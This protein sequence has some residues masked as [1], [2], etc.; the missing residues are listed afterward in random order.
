[1]SKLLA[2]TLGCICAYVAMF[3]AILKG[4]KFNAAST[5]QDY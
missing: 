5:L 3:V 1:M 4:S 2:F